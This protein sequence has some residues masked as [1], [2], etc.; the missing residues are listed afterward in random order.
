MRAKNR[1]KREAAAKAS[2]TTD[3]D[4]PRIEVGD[5]LQLGVCIE[6]NRSATS[7]RVFCTLPREGIASNLL[8]NLLTDF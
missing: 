2:S 7:S 6:H 3:A 1:T 4:E 5:L 8:D